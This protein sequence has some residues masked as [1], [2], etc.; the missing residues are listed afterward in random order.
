MKTKLLYLVVFLVVMNTTVCFG[1]LVRP[2]SE[3]ISSFQSLCNRHSDVASYESIGKSVQNNDIWLFKFG[4]PDGGVVMWDAQLHGGEGLGTEIFWIFCQW[5]L[6]SNTEKANNY[7]KTN[8]LLVIPVV[9]ID[10]SARQNMRRH[11]TATETQGTIYEGN[12]LDISFGVNLNRNFPTNFGQSGT[13]NASDMND[14]R[15]IKG[16]SEPEA[17]A[18]IAC[19]QKYKPKIY[20]N[21]HQWAGPSIIY[22][23][24]YS[25]MTFVNEI[26]SKQQEYFDTE[27]PIFNGNPIQPFPL[28]TGLAGGYSAYEEQRIITGT[29]ALLI[30]IDPE[31]GYSWEN[32]GG[33]WRMPTL[34]NIQQFYY[35]QLRPLILSTLDVTAIEYVPPTTD[36][37]G[38][39]FQFIVEH[40]I[41]ISAIS[42]STV[43]LL[44][45]VAMKVK[46]K[47]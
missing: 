18:L 24:T 38:D 5:L 33:S 39:W 45:I 40:E 28:R 47:K 8:Y 11:Y 29:Q 35:M 30:E 17:R 20:V 44:T 36:D 15:G 1:A 27:H 10:T 12:A 19:W 7:L 13:S 22:S 42:F 2:K 21:T 6:E 25:N 23:A 26:N 43:L 14:Y 32:R 37:D 4:N 31:A 3:T 16:A 41:E 9:N 46:R 34:T